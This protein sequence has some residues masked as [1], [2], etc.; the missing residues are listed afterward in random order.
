MMSVTY[1]FVG[2]GTTPDNVGIGLGGAEIVLGDAG[3]VHAESAGA[4][5]TVDAMR[6]VQR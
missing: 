3:S 6:S 1:D 2:D 5:S 4:G